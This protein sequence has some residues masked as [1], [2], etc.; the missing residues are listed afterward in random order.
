MTAVIEPSVLDQT[1]RR[2]DD[3]DKR[4]APGRPAQ[5]TPGPQPLDL[6]GAVA[7]LAATRHRNRTQQA[8]ADIGVERVALDAEPFGGFTRCQIA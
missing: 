4:L 8:A 5:A 6:I 7:A 1:D 3:R 2:V